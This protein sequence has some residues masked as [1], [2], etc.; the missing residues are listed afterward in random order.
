[1]PAKALLYVTRKSG[2]T[3]AE[4]KAHYETVHVPFIKSLAGDD[5]PLSHRRLYLARPAPGDDDS[6][7]VAVVVGSQEDFPYDA[8]TELTFPDETTLKR[9]FKRRMEQG[10]KGTVDADEEKFLDGSKLKL[11]ILGEVNETTR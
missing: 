7:P 1:M 3:P 2:M 9:F 4:F 8:I 6:Y 10:T 5:F 11:V